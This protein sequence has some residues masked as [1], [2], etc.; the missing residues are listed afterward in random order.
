MF[1]IVSIVINIVILA[2]IDIIPLYYPFI[3]IFPPQL[4]KRM[5]KLSGGGK[6]DIHRTGFLCVGQ[7]FHFLTRNGFHSDKEGYWCYHILEV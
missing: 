7:K 3:C 2:I 5:S 1:G 4:W 6:K